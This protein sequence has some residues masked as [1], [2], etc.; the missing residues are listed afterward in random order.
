MQKFYFLLFLY[1]LHIQGYTTAQAQKIDRI[2]EPLQEKKYPKAKSNLEKMQKDYPTDPIYFLGAGL[3]YAD[4]LNPDYEPFTAFKNLK[5]AKNKWQNLELKKIQKLAENDKIDTVFISNNINTL[6]D[7]ELQKA[8]QNAKIEDL[9][10]YTEQFAG[11]PQALKAEENMYLVAFAEAEK[12]NTVLGYEIF[13]QKYAKAPQIMQ[14]IDKIHDLSFA[15]AQ[16]THTP[17]SY[18]IFVQKY[19]NAP[20]IDKAVAIGA[21]LTYEIATKSNTRDDLMTFIDS[22]PNSPHLQEA[23]NRLEN[24]YFKE[25]KIQIS[26]IHN[27]DGNTDVEVFLDLFL[28]NLEGKTVRYFIDVVNADNTA[29]SSEYYENIFN[30]I[31]P[32]IAYIKQEN[33][34][35]D[36]W[37]GISNNV[38]IPS[39]D[40]NRYIFFKEQQGT[41]SC[42][43]QYYHCGFDKITQMGYENIVFQNK[44]A[45]ELIK[46]APKSIDKCLSSSSENYILNHYKDIASR[47]GK[48]LTLK[49]D[50]GKT[51]TLLST[52][53]DGYDSVYDE[54]YFKYSFV[55]YNKYFDCFIIDK[56]FANTLGPNII[57][58]FISKANGNE[59]MSKNQSI[60]FSLSFSPETDKILYVEGG[61]KPIISIY[62][63][64]DKMIVRESVDTM[65]QYETVNSGIGGCAFTSLNWINNNT[66]QL[67]FNGG[68][69]HTYHFRNG[70]WH[71]E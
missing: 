64:E 3:F 39:T 36:I 17:T 33:V 27:T 68:K 1:I 23:K 30:K 43:Q 42:I 60:A 21:K 31:N 53:K 51:K 45:E 11:T 56:Q 19:P 7:N 49:L 37:I 55:G 9:R 13:R 25:K 54:K 63:S 40:A 50:N 26:T 66:F 44:T 41:F 38:D 32:K 71:L 69:V 2:I 15:Q 12:T 47:E 52:A 48:K 10:K 34:I 18:E 6:L 59:L 57:V 29:S 46:D 61:G 4:A 62:K 65:P 5:E 28:D 20:Q 16:A 14:A 35:S 58:L 70:S 8:I 24:S 22:H 67:A